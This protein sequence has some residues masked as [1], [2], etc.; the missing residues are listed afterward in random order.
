MPERFKED[1]GVPKQ[2]HRENLFNM[3]HQA[4]SSKQAS[5]SSIERSELWKNPAKY[6]EA[7]TH[8]GI[9]RILKESVGH[10]SEDL[11]VKLHS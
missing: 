7:K 3:W 4:D 2:C 5:R 1:T 11:E 9:C 8:A 10:L 6:K